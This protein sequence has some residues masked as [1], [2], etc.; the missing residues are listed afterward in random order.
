MTKKITGQ[1]PVNETHYQFA[2]VDF[3]SRCS[4][5]RNKHHLY[6]RLKTCNCFYSLVEES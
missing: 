6:I 5:N 4:W 3:T 1:M 2:A